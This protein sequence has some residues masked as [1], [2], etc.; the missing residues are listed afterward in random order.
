MSST[1][2][3]TDEIEKYLQYTEKLTKQ[4]TELQ[5]ADIPDNEYIQELKI[6]RKRF[7]TLMDNLIIKL[8]NNDV[9]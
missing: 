6:R 2:N 9:E 4:I 5:A 3:T 1:H 7:N 8:E